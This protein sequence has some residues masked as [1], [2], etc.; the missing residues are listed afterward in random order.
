MGS[1]YYFPFV[2][3]LRGQAVD[4]GMLRVFFVLSHYQKGEKLKRCYV[5]PGA[6]AYFVEQGIGSPPT[7]LDVELGIAGGSVLHLTVDSQEW[8]RFLS[9]VDPKDNKF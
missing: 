3:P 9:I 2:V 4:R 6:V 7:T 5:M 8:K 1:E